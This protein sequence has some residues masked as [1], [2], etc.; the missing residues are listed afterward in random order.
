MSKDNEVF[1]SKDLGGSTVRPRVV[2][3]VEQSHQ[4]K[5]VATPLKISKKGRLNQVTTSHFK[6][7]TG[8]Q[9]FYL[10]HGTLSPDSVTEYILSTP[11][12]HEVHL[13]SAISVD[14]EAV[15]EYWEGTTYT[16]GSGT[17]QQFNCNNR[18]YSDQCGLELERNPTISDSGSLL[19]SQKVGN[20]V[21]NNLIAGQNRQSNE[22]VLRLD[23]NYMY[24]IKEQSSTE[25]DVSYQ[26]SYY[27]EEV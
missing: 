8:E 16:S 15:I 23:T 21:R 12:E 10:N 25:N 18:N 27:R 4:S 26:F 11:T 1:I 20:I 22:V 14:S 6:I 5:S 9:F 2:G 17:A 24:K 13:L 3:G 7:H 19:G